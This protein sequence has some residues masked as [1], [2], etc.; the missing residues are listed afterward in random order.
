MGDPILLAGDHRGVDLKQALKERLE[1]AGHEVRDLGP[2]G[3]ESVNYAEFVAPAARAV[4]VGE[5]S[6]AI[7]ICGTGLGVSYTANR[8]PRVRAALVHDVETATLA[9][10]HND[11]NVLALSANRTSVD[12]A[13]AIVEAWLKVPFEGG[14]HSLRVEQIDSLTRTHDGALIRQDPTIANILRREASRQAQG[15]ELIASENFVSEAVLEAVGSVATN[16]Y[17]E[18][19]PGRRYYGGCDVLDEAENLARDR[20]KEIFGSEHVNVQPHSG[21]QANECVYRA[22]LEVGDRILAMN[23]DHG[24]HLTHG[25]PV[26]FSGKLYDIVPYGVEQETETID[27]DALREL[28]KKH[29]PKLIQCGATAYSR[30]I[31]FAKFRE[32]ADEVGA[33]LFA[34]IAH[35]AGLVATGHHP[36]PVGQAQLISTTTHKT[37]RGPRGGMILCD[38][39]FAKKVDSAVFPGGQ[40]GPLMHVIAGKAVAFG[41]ALQ[42]D[43]R[44]YCGQI[45]ANARTLAAA[46]A[47]RGFRIVSGGT[48]NHLFLL[49]L[50]GR[51]ITGKLAQ[52][53]LDEAG[54][55]TNKNMVPFDPRKPFVTSGVRIGTPALTTRG[56]A[57]AEMEAVADMLGRVLESPED[58]G[59]RD[60]VREE[61]RALCDRF[62]LY[63]DRWQ[64]TV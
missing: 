10:E 44:D 8:F 14:R 57:E 31:D 49:S 60:R 12:D 27:Y 37:L 5:A 16:K 42:P 63:A 53:I 22:V 18:G 39:E 35:I 24:G 17:A 61:V 32:I 2:T 13:W 28:A 9:R 41:E 40:G 38:G 55:T 47:K 11:A 20:A 19:Y 6:R 48:D 50:V 26:N 15:L 52:N 7:V 30:I 43:F 54:I 64:P 21:S 4:S 34:D 58:T 46:L 45:I 1:A 56:M 23:L 33:L 3:D 25:S 51:E 62:P 36:T 29:R 59:V